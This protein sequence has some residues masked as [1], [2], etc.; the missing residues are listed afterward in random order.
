[1]FSDFCSG[2][3]YIGSL[4]FGSLYGLSKS[5]RKSFK[6]AKIQAMNASIIVKTIREID[7]R[8][9][10]TIIFSNI[11]T[12]LKFDNTIYHKKANYGKSNSNLWNGL[13]RV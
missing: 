5:E 13:K 9:K 2:S 4:Y 12:S 6:V 11:A 1:M 7:I 8:T 10:T 3:S